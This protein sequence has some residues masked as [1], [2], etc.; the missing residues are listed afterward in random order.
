MLMTTKT[1]TAV[2]ISFPPLLLEQAKILAQEENRTV[3]EL[4]CEALRQHVSE[5]MWKR[6]RHFGTLSAEMA[7]V[8]N[9]EEIVAL[10][11]QIRHRMAE[12]EAARE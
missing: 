5:R 11:R 4:V 1:D 9:E 12:E 8:K 6:L 7:N 3:S 2:S 10:V